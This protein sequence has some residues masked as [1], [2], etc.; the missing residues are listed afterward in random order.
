MERNWVDHGVISDSSAELH[1]NVNVFEGDS[2]HAAFV[3]KE[4]WDGG[5]ET[6]TNKIPKLG[7][8]VAEWFLNRTV[9][10]GRT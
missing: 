10:Y 2:T 7:T 1:S 9:G 3:G 6:I 5:E 4:T 8:E